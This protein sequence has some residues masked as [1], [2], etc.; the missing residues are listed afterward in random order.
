[1]KKWL[2]ITLV[3]G[4][5]ACASK[6]KSKITNA[7]HPQIDSEAQTEPWETEPTVTPTVAEEVTDTETPESKGAVTAT[8]V[9]SASNLSSS[10]DTAIK[11]QKDDDIYKFS[12]QVLMQS[13]EDLKALNSMALYH[14]KK[15]RFEASKYLL[16]KAIKHHPNAYQ[17]HNNLGVVLLAMGETRDAIKSFRKVLELRSDDPMA[18]A[19]L[20]SIF[21]QEKNYIK[22]SVALELAYQNGLRDS[23]LLN[24]YA[25]A[26]AA[27]GQFNKSEEIYEMIIRDNSLNREAL[28]NYS[29][30]LI[31]HLKKYQKGLD[32]INRLK[33]AGASSEQRSKIVALENKAKSGTQ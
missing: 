15:G 12:S 3:L 10:L 14:Y 27:T 32:M 7:A 22:A 13:P 23:R 4:L 16:S 20:G 18:S 8:N 30:L 28:L 19:N 1:M 2:L 31:D 26:L 33:L 29:I 9:S 21:V 25:I 17:A 6:P 11:N 24:N 5:G